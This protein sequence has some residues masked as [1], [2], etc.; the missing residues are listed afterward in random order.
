MDK[1]HT[2]LYTVYD[3]SNCYGSNYVGG[4]NV[5]N[6][7]FLVIENAFY[8]SVQNYETETCLTVQ[9]DTNILVF[10]G[11]Q[12]IG[13]CLI[14]AADRN[15]LMYNFE[16]KVCTAFDTY[17][18]QG[19][20]S[21]NLDIVLKKVTN[22]YGWICKLQDDNTF[23]DFCFQSI[24][25]DLPLSTV[26][27]NIDVL[28][29]RDLFTT[30]DINV[31]QQDIND[32]CE[33][34]DSVQT[35]CTDSEQVMYNNNN[36]WYNSLNI[37]VTDVELQLNIYC[38]QFEKTIVVTVANGVFVFDPSFT[39][40]LKDKVY[41]FDVTD[42]TNANHPLRFRSDNTNQDIAFTET[43]GVITISFTKVEDITIYCTN[44]G[45]SMGFSFTVKDVNPSQVTTTTQA[46][47]TTTAVPTTTTQAP[48]TT[49]AP[50]ITDPPTTTQEPTTTPAPSEGFP[51]WALYTLIG[52]GSA[53]VLAVVLYF[54]IKACR[55]GS[56][57]EYQNV[58][59]KPENN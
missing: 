10:N 38:L 51:D 23:T 9:P 43:N 1:T 41:K 6:P 56:K 30:T 34:V 22:A 17:T 21:D 26:K 37:N 48:T 15:F 25:A 57:V 18:N 8:N 44:H 54:S 50:T 42:A 59:T 5:Y 40:L 28:T 46:P 27:Q 11:V 49:V 3:S 13:N 55:N 39:Y 45:D 12:D 52:V 33:Q 7:N 29:V 20:C 35:Y 47:T 2:Y 36:D 53:G 4:V 58:G 16:T 32:W 24:Y 31:L 14:N 19:S